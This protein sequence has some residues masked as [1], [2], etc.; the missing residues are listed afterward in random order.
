MTIYLPNPLLHET[1]AEVDEFSDVLLPDPPLP[2]VPSRAL[3]PC[4]P[5]D[6]DAGATER[7]GPQPP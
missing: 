2:P 4:R 3:T 1:G 6:P 5:I 7:L